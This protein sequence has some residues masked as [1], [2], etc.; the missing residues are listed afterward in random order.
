MSLYADLRIQA[1]GAPGADE[2]EVVVREDILDPGRQVLSPQGHI[3]ANPAQRLT[4]E[5]TGAAVVVAIRNEIVIELET[6]AV[7]LLREARFVEQGFGKFWIVRIL[8]RVGRI[9]R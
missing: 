3:D 8:L 4:H 2:L 9:E 7:G 6:P 5:F 1:V